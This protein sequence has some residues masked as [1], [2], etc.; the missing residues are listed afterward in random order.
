MKQENWQRARKQEQ[1]EKRE[2][3]ILSAAEELYLSES[4]EK[5]TMQK[6]ARKVGC[7]QSNMYRYFKTKEEIFLS[8]F[9]DDV[10]LWAQ[11]TERRFTEPLS[12]EAFAREW[13]DMMRGQERLIKLNSLLYMTLER[14]SSREVYA[15]TKKAL[16]EKLTTMTT[17]LSRALLPL[18]TE[19]V[20]SLLMF[21]GTFA[22][23]AWPSTQYSVMQKEVL[24]ELEL[25]Y[26]RVDFFTLLEDTIQKY[27]K[28]LMGQ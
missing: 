10:E 5:V 27:L 28:G 21:M 13:T 1:I 14:N 9:I 2:G 16:M 22:A 23:G 25:D 17:A 20:F 15:H 3:Q 12:V 19:E 4:Y 24:K 6:I 7:S 18:S 8:F 11:E 26:I